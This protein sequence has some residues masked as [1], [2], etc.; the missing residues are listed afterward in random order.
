[1]VRRGQRNTM[2]QNLLIIAIIFMAIWLLRKV[3]PAGTKP[4]YGKAKT[5]GESSSPNSAY[6]AVSIHS[7]KDRCTDVQALVGQRFLSSEAPPL[8]LESCTS[9]KC[10]CVYMHHIDRRGGTDRRVIHGHEGVFVY[11]GSHDRRIY[12]GRRASNL[13][14]A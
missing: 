4:L 9:E 10:R 1:M 5:P 7:Y 2:A 11:P 12:L 14:L 3:F 13:D 6:K 8:P